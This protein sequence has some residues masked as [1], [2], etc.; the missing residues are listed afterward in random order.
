MLIYKNDGK[1]HCVSK[2]ALKLAGYNDIA[3]FLD[4]HNDFSELFVKKPGYIY[5]F[6]N[7]SWLSFLRNANP[8]QKRVLINTRDNA[9]YECTLELELLFPI[10]I[11]EETPEYYYQIEFKNLKLAEGSAA[12]DYFEAPT[13]SAVFNDADL[14]HEMIDKAYETY[15]G[16]PE[17]ETETSVESITFGE[18]EEETPLFAEE[19]EKTEE[20]VNFSTVEETPVAVETS[21]RPTDEP[22]DLVDFAFGDEESEATEEKEEAETAPSLDEAF[23]A[24][25]EQP[26]IELKP[27]ETAATEEIGTEAGQPVNEELPEIAIEE[28][29]A[30]SAEPMDAASEAAAPQSETNIS[31][32]EMPDIR[33]VS[34]T[35]GLPETMVKAFVKEFVDTYF[36]DIH[37][38]KMAMQSNHL[39]IVKKEAMKLK[40]IASNLM[41]DP[42]A[43]T[44]E[45]ILAEEEDERIIALWNEID[46]YIH[47]LA[48][49]YAPATKEPEEKSALLAETT[50]TAE[51][52]V[53]EK[54]A[55]TAAES[56]ESE[57]AVNTLVLEEIDKGETI[58]FDPNEAANALGLPESLIVEFVNDF[59]EQAREEKV[60]FETAFGNEEITTIN[61]VA[62]K[63][64]GVAANLRIE[65]MRALM[66]E[67]QHAQTLEA[68]EK[69]L[70]AFYSKLAALSKTMAKEFA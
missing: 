56:G 2:K 8:E 9:T 1:L 26:E 70:R 34:G 3:E 28:T 39:H 60:N 17:P 58:E 53:E 23:K 65:D 61:E 37:E 44:L 66:E 50:E 29:A 21:A 25:E 35:L 15:E 24:L 6:E 64:K 46:T 55:V 36:A 54:P 51:A 22:L 62:H 19:E 63:L 33:T 49:L 59:V 69:P 41:M 11:E 18:T 43:Q 16:T 32:L 30:M 12:G 10:D 42:L 14:D 38:V 13:E 48:E 45:E 67:V 7:F 5:N 47:Q 57:T 68:A 40:G 52:E 27:E 4:S 20:I 31:S